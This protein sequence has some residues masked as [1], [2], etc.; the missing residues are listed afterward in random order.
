MRRMAKAATRLAKSYT[1]E[2]DVDTYVTATK[3]ENS[4]SE[5]VNELLSA[6]HGSGTKLTRGPLKPRTFFPNAT[7]SGS[8]IFRRRSRNP[9]NWGD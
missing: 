8:D 3:G 7:N 9:C 5:R 4:A 6:C 1:I 2:A